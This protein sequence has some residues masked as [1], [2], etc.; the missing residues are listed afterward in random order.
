MLATLFPHVHRRYEASRY[1]VD[2]DAFATW[3]STVGYSH[4]SAQGH[5]FRLKQMLEHA[6]RRLGA[7]FTEAQLHEAFTVPDGRQIVYRGTQ[8]TFLAFLKHT[9]RFVAAPSTDRFGGLRADYRHYL[10]EVWGFSGSTVAQ[11]DATVGDLLVRMLGRRKGL[12]DLTNE[13]IERYVQ[14]RSQ[15]VTRQTLQHVVA[16]LRAFLRYGHSQ[17][18]LPCLLPVI[19]TPRTYRG[20]LPPRAIDWPLVVKL[21]ASVDRADRR[22]WRDYAVLHLMAYYG[23][24]PSEIAAL[25][26][27]AIDWTAKTLRVAQRK[28]RSELILPLADRTIAMLRRYLRFGRPPSAHPQLFLRARCPYGPLTHYGIVDIFYTRAQASGLALS[29]ASS[30]GLRHAFAMRLLRRG[31]GVKAIGDLLGHRSL[32]STCVYLRLD[33]DMLRA[34]ALPVPLQTHR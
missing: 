8:R 28:T 30:Y 15:E 22:G 33:T 18:V 11:H 7:C 24:R 17:G 10:V 27:A 23:L 12:S 31:V 3:L 21:L 25:D 14:T 32:E 20:E 6:R 34:V 5:V 2:L 4:D 26:V 13:D 29:G 1:A 19:D 9:D 16:R